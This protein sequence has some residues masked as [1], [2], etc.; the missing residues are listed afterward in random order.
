MHQPGMIDGADAD[1]SAVPS[2]VSVWK[3]YLVMLVAVGVLY[4]ATAQRG[5]AWQDSGIFQW[6]VLNFDVVGWLGLALAHPLLIVLGKAAGFVP[7]GSLAWRINMV[8]VICGAVAVANVA[9]L[10]RRLAP[11]RPSAAWIAG[12]FLAF[13]HTTWW[14]ATICESQAIL[15]ALFTTELHVL[16]GLHRRPTSRLALLLGL[17]NG[18][19]LTAHNL[20]LLALPAYGLTVIGLCWSGRLRWR[21]VAYM[22]VGWLV[23]ASGFLAIIASQAGDVGLPVAVRSAL[24]GR[25]WQGAV[26]AGSSSAA[27]KGCG[28][29]LYNFPN[30]AL[31]LMLVGLW[32]LRKRR[33]GGISLALVYLAG[34]YFLFAVRYPVPDQFMFFLPFYAMV[35][36]LAGVGVASICSLPGRKWLIWLVGASVVLAPIVYSAAP[37]VWGPMGLPLPGRKDLPFRDARGYWLQPWKNREDSAG[38]FAR[39]ALAEAP[40]GGTIIADMTCLPPLQWTQRVEGVGRDVR[41]LP[42]GGATG[43]VIAAGTPDVFVVSRLRGSYPAWLDEAATLEKDDPQNVL[44]RAVW[45]DGDRK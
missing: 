29:I 1:L 25:S 31:P 24:F 2:G 28:Y 12:G 3:L 38:R 16:V 44:Y 7:L 42:V 32:S 27:I 45:M 41:L 35:S 23:G 18:L 26:L 34:V 11:Q 19:A 21:S 22:I 6:R 10:V 20:A 15:L 40:P 36:I 43:A 13:A 9:T 33:P 17:I 14:L 30:L 37:S 39:S 5:S 8:S 4:G